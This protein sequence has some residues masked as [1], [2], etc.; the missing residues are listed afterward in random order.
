MG[1]RSTAK[2]III[3]DEKILLNKCYD[4][5]NG[6]YYSLPGGGQN[7]FETLENAVVRECLEETG[8]KVKILRFCALFEE[9]C[10]NPKFTEKYA[11]YVHKMYHIF[12]CD[13]ESFDRKELSE[14][15][16]MQ[17]GCEWIDLKSIDSI[18]IMPT[19]IKENMCDIIYNEKTLFLGSENIM[20]GHG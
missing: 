14:T 1:I 12:L 4:E 13:I 17:T 3:H 16:I 15:D 9:I 11:D 5:Y 7:K 8:Y 20:Y 6:Y 19:V 18:K 2:A 10:T